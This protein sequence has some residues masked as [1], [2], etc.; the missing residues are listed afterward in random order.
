MFYH[1]VAG[2]AH[3]ITGYPKTSPVHSIGHVVILAPPPKKQIGKPVD[4]LELSLGQ[5]RHPTEQTRVRQSKKLKID[6]SRKSKAHEMSAPI[7][8]FVDCSR[9]VPRIVATAIKIAIIFREQVH[10]VE[11]KT[12]EVTQLLSFNKADVKERCAIETRIR[13]LEWKHTKVKICGVT[14]QS[15]WY[16]INLLNNND[17]VV[18]FLMLKKRV[19]IREQDTQMLITISVRHNHCQVSPG[20]AILGLP[21]SIVNTRMRLM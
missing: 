14:T 18:S 1:L 4:T 15:H 17:H 11:N 10:I 8:E 20:N 3:R 7:A 9:H 13:Q 5:G 19:H 16:K 21:F 6:W 2:D 12:V